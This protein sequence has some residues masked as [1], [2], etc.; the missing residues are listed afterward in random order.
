MGIDNRRYMADDAAS[1][2]GRRRSQS[3]WS[4]VTTLIV[5]NVIVFLLQTLTWRTGLLEYW[6]RLSFDGLLHGQIWRLTTYDFL[7]QTSE[8]LPLH[9]LFNMWLLYLAGRRVEDKYGSNEFLGFYLLAGVLSGIGFILWGLLTRNP[10]PA[11]GASGAVVAVM[12]VY[13]MN[14]PHERWYIWGIL[15]VPVMI[16]AGIAAALDILPMLREL[17]GNPGPGHVAHAAHVG[18]MLFGFLYV[19]FGWRVTTLLE[20][21]DSKKWKRSFQRRPQLK[22][23]HPELEKRTIDEDVPKEVENR[24]DRILQ[25][26]SL[27]GEKSLTDEERHFLT[28]TSRRY[29]NRK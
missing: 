7:H 11:I 20:S 1:S 8:G 23:H 3:G 24:L 12:I 22:V 16:L 18:G 2:W 26:I 27:E 13:A 19:K 9:L 14:W 25:K 28:E 5:I 17:S 4:M 29:R 21:W 15:P 10:S 6:L